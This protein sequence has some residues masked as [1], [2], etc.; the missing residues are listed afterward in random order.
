MEMK[1]TIC[2][3]TVTYTIYSGGTPCPLCLG[4]GRVSFRTWLGHPTQPNQDRKITSTAFPW[5]DSYHAIASS[6]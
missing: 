1:C 4:E 2:K 3:A 6:L 5:N